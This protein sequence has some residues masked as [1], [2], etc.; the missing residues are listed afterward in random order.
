MRCGSDSG[1][2]R[3]VFREDPEV[4]ACAPRWARAT[5]DFGP[6]G[7]STKPARTKGFVGDWNAAFIMIS[8]IYLHFRINRACKSVWAVTRADQNVFSERTIFSCKD[9][10]NYY[11]L[12]ILLLKSFTGLLEESLHPRK[13]DVDTRQAHVFHAQRIYVTLERLV[14]TRYTSSRRV[15]V[16]LAFLSA[17]FYLTRHP[18]VNHNADH[19]PLHRHHGQSKMGFSTPP[20][21]SRYSSRWTRAKHGARHDEKQSRPHHSSGGRS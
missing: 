5:D 4:L 13:S 20:W 17:H 10:I 7:I 16:E 18:L 1:T 3:V 2:R 12:A 14:A 11:E 21:K 15:S 9:L 8:R 19:R 6:R